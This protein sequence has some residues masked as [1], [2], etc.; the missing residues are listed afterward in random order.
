[1]LAL[2]ISLIGLDRPRPDTGGAVTIRSLKGETLVLSLDRAQTVEVGGS[3]GTTTI[4]IEDGSVRFVDSPCPHKLC[5]KKGR[6]S[7]VGDFVA[8]LPNGV[9]AQITGKSD[10]DAI[11]P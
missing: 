7:R 5:I 10:Y 4:V 3:L 2:G 9:V 8:C 1:V 11:T 6:I